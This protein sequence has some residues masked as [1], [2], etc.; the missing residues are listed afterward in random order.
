MIDGHAQ[1]PNGSGKK[2]PSLIMDF[3]KFSTYLYI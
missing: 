3:C 1:V 2:W